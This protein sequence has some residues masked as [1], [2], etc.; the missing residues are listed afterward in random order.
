MKKLLTSLTIAIGITSI[1]PTVAVEQH[2]SKLDQL[3]NVTQVAIER[4]VEKL[5]SIELPEV[6]YSQDDLYWLAQI[7]SAEAKGE[8][9]EGQIAVGNVILNRVASKNFPNSIK[10]VIFQKGQ[11]SPVSNGRLYD[12]P[13]DSAKESAKK[14][15]QGQRVIGEDV[16]YF[17]SYKIVSSS[18]WIRTRPT[19]KDIGNHRFAK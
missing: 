16:L 13:Y 4:K 3:E 12:K 14:V 5:Q 19:V 18:N 11:F 6:T 17:Y 7:I 9:E 15:L 8:S 10:E 1:V 2:T